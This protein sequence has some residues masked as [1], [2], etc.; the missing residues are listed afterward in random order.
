[1]KENITAKEMLEFLQ[2]EFTK[3]LYDKEH[4]DDDRQLER[5]IWQKE[6]VEALIQEPVN[7]QKNGKVTTGF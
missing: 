6:L 3:A 5:V 2:E 4:F 1:M 7:L